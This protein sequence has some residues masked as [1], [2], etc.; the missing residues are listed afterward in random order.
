MKKFYKIG[1]IAKMYK[2]STRTIRYYEEVELLKKEEK[3]GTKY[4]Y[5]NLEQLQ[6]LEIIL[7]LRK[8]NFSIKE[9]KEIFEEKRMDKIIEIFKSNLTSIKIEINSLNTTKK[10]IENLLNY[11]KETKC[12]Y[13]DG[14]K[15]IKSG[16]D[17][18]LF[19][20]GGDIMGLNSEFYFGENTVKI[21][22]LKP[23]KIAYY[24]AISKTPEFDAWNVMKQ[25]VKKNQL[26]LSPFI[27]YFG[28]DNPSPSI[29]KDEYGYEVWVMT[30]KDIKEDNI[31]KIKKFEG[32]LYAVTTNTYLP[33]IGKT[34][35]K[36]IKWVEKSKYSIRS[37]DMCLEEHIVIDLEDLG[38]ENIQ[39]DLYLPIN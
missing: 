3:E 28:F 26:H 32:G 20:K 24:R 29:E 34:W 19:Q 14:I 1:E 23:A 17:E 21:V 22:R 18:I 31:I 2:I 25:W 35:K 27:R 9:I 10:F 33:E 37:N 4:R 39:I 5:Y 7:I 12:D 15:I 13:S 36:L 16:I 8:L 6:K 38:T 30:D 11:F